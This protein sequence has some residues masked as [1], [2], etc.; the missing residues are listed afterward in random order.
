MTQVNGKLTDQQTGQ[1]Y[2]IN[3]TLQFVFSKLYSYITILM[4]EYYFINFEIQNLS[5]IISYITHQ[6]VN[7][8]SS[9]AFTCV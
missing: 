8:A 4:L 3:G 2:K 1:I 6:Y 5:Q 7:F 9:Y